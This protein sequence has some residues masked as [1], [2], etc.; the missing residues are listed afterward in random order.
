MSNLKEILESVQKGQLDIE[1]ATKQLRSGMYEDIGHSRVDHDRLERNGKA[2]VIFGEGKTVGQLNDIM[3]SLKKRGQDV[4]VT[5][6][7]TEKAD[8]LSNAYP[9]AVYH[10]SARIHTR[11]CS[12]SVACTAG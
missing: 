12:N 9:T 1:E 5:R 2:E 6:L 7:S 10:E 11:S 8:Q 3:G 4:L